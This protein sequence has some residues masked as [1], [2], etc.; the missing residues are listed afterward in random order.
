MF[1]PDSGARYG[2]GVNWIIAHAMGALYPRTEALPGIGDVGVRDFLRRYR[3][4]SSTLMWLGLVAGSLLFVFSPLLTVFVPLPS[5][6]LPRRLLD[7][8]AYRV[9]Y[10]RIYLLRQSVFLVKLA[11]GLVWG[12]H[13]EVR[14]RFALPP[15]EADP[16]D[17]RTS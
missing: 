10:S 11:A 14:A 16:D 2:V 4:E 12:Q 8:H 7:E 9:T 5:F 6:F 15:Y 17:W 3:R 13:A 1:P